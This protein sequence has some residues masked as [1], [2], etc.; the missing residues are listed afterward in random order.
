MKASEV[1]NRLK[2][3]LLS[4]TETEE[5]AKTTTKEDVE[6][7]EQAPEVQ[8][9]NVSEESSSDQNTDNSTSSE[10]IREINYSADEVT[11]DSKE[12][13]KSEE[14]EEEPQEE[15]VE[16][17]SPEYATKDEVA[18]VRAMVE[19]LRGM[20]ETKEEAYAEVPQEL[21]SD[22]APTE[23]LSHSPENQV[24]E[25]LGASISPNQNLNTTYGRVLRALSK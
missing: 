8:N 21:S 17:K 11:S 14:L 19:K 4:S 22:E 7:K 23:P 24:S 12:E 3:V 15:I 10:D 16:E 2:D 25:K 20:I 13:I 6:L 1:I 9:E 18:E 5:V